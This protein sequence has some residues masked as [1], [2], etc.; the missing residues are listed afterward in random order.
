MGGENTRLSDVS[1]HKSVPIPRTYRD[2]R[3]LTCEAESGLF[4]YSHGDMF[5]AV[6]GRLAWLISR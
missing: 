2:S 5:S 4:Q 1:H 6:V 3:A